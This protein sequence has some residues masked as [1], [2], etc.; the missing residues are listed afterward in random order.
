M[1]NA[2]DNMRHITITIKGMGW[3]FACSILVQ[4]LMG[5]NEVYPLSSDLI[6]SW[7][8]ALSI[9][10]KGIATPKVST[11]GNGNLSG[12]I[13]SF[14]F[15]SLLPSTIDSLV[16]V[17]KTLMQGKH[18]LSSPQLLPLSVGPNVNP[19]LFFL[20]NS[21]YMMAHL[22]VIILHVYWICPYVHFV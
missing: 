14:S 5:H 1:K 17:L 16:S 18:F 19:I 12:Y 10:E 7:K 2:Q 13:F 15:L 4:P 8:N 22:W 20:L 6:G 3:R 21:D 9:D 11:R